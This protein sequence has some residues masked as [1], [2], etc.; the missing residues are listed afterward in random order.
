MKRRAQPMAMTKLVTTPA[1]ETTQVAATVVPE[2]PRV[3]GT[4]RARRR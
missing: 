2:V 4:G 1:L 3:I